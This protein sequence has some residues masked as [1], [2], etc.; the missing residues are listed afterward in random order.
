M[1]DD[2]TRPQSGAATQAISEITNAVPASAILGIVKRWLIATLVMCVPFGT[3]LAGGTGTRL[4]LLGTAGGPTPKARRAAP[5]EAIQVGNTIYLVDCGNGVGRQLVLAG[6]PLEQVR[7]IFIT[8]HH[9]DHTADL[10]TLP[11]LLWANGLAGVIT[12]HGPPPL[13]KSVKAG[14][15]AVAFDVDTRVKDEGRTPLRDQ[16][17]IDEFTRE[18]IVYQDDRVTVRA[19][20][21]SHPPIVDAYA[22][23]FDTPGRSIVISGDTAPSP[24]LVELARGADVLVHEVLL[25]GPDETAAWLGLPLDHPLVQHVL[26]SHTSF[27]DVGKIARDA[28]VTKL[29]LTHFVPGNAEVDRERVLGEI[30]KTFSGE[31]VL[32]E[33]LMEVN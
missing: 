2:A 19:A 3:G 33:D 22:Y 6:L 18:G 28:G 8:H 5:A 14:L 7:E 25:L 16:L 17:R 32:G 29:V 30:R 26:K 20:R 1:A 27:R 13:R 31:V 21:V 9:S 24:A 10:T 11:L 23:R 12:L 4:V 15:R